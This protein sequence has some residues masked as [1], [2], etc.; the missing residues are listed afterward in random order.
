MWRWGRELRKSRYKYRL[1]IPEFGGRR[2]K[3]REGSNV[4][5]KE[6]QRVLKMKMTSACLK[7]IEESETAER[8]RLGW[9]SS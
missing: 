6:W 2:S 9:A 4:M 5:E 7:S 3:G 1:F 8:G